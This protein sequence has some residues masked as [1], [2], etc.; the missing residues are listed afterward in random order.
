MNSG[1]RLQPA[2]S[3]AVR[4]VVISPVRDEAKYIE[5]TMRSMARQT[6]V[7]AQWIVVD[8]GSTD[9]TQAIIDCWASKY[10]WITPVHRA[11]RVQPVLNQLA[12]IAHERLKRSM[13]SIVGTTTSQQRIGSPG[14]DRR[15][16]GLRT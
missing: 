8:D 1:S 7:P 10:P 14:E 16:C 3:R 11:N 15:R 4:Y 9:G 12:V 5:E 6:V 13:H 2:D